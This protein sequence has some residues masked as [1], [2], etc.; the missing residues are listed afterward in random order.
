MK[1]FYFSIALIL[2]YSS[3]CQSSYSQV[4]V[5]KNAG[6]SSRTLFS[7]EAK[8]IEFNLIQRIIGGSDTSISVAVSVENV[9]E[10]KV[11][12]STGVIVNTNLGVSFTRSTFSQL[13]R[14]E[15]YMELSKEEFHE[16]FTF[17]NNSM[18]KANPMQEIQTAF[19]LDLSD[20]FGISLIYDGN[21]W[22]Y[23]F[24][25]DDVQY[26]VEF[27]ESID[28]IVKLKE[29]DELSKSSF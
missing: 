12:R 26:Q 18:G 22:S 28:I 10:E 25:L 6:L 3:F 5:F 16:V 17:I 20:K 27:Q 11:G 24:R 15:G 29:M 8:S 23:L 2:S 1:L 21:E 9:G 7:S 4:T 14:N 13:Y 19:N